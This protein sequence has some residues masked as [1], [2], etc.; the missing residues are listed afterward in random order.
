MRRVTA[1]ISIP[2]QGKA[3]PIFQEDA[4]ERDIFCLTEVGDNT[5]GS[6]AKEGGTRGSGAG[7]DLG[8]GRQHAANDSHSITKTE[9][10]RN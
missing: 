9:P 4:G 6:K 7:R 5:A 10:S 3:S 8:G 1:L 2:L